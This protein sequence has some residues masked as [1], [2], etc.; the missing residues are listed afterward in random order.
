MDSSLNY[1]F[2]PQ[3]G[4]QTDFLTS[5]ADIVIYGGAA[6]GGKTYGILLDAI[7][8]VTKKHYNAAFFRRE[9]TQIRSPGGLWEESKKMYIPFGGKANNQEMTWRFPK[10]SE[11]AL[12]KMAGLQYEDDKFNYQGAQFDCVY[13]DELTHFTESQFWYMISRLRSQGGYVKPYARGTC[14]PE[15]G[16]VLDMIEWWINSDGYPIPERSGVLR[17]FIRYEDALHWFDSYDYAKSWCEKMKLEATVEPQSFTFIPA[18]IED[19]KILME[20]DPSY[21]GKLQS[22]GEL[23]KQKLLYGNWRIKPSGKLFRIN[24]F[25]DF[26]ITPQFEFKAITVDTAQEI[27]SAN[28]FTVMQLW[29]KKDKKIYLAEQARGKFEFDDQVDILMSMIISH[30]PQA[31]LI[32][33]KANGSALIQSIRRR[34]AD[35]G[36]IAQVIPVQRSRDKY[37]RG[38]DTQGYIKSG[39]V[40]L[41]KTSDYYAAFAAEAVAFSPENKNK[42]GIHDDQVDCMMDAV[43][44]M[45]INPIVGAPEAADIGMRWVS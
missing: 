25:Q 22:L 24:D 32:E 15:P 34:I 38:Y 21:V 45:L 10:L 35:A 39:Y 8:W 41:N 26:I 18:N 3:P 7:R 31:V 28:D 44:F 42:S 23:E 12:I 33:A 27:K 30:K 14:N 20:N 40:Y 43:E 2:A 6:G 11:H 13:F 9:T 37:S 19:N 29:G 17:W 5:P 1:K 36:L 4:K 16:W